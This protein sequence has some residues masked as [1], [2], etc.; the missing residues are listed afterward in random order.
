MEGMI[1][2][3]ILVHGPMAA[4]FFWLLYHTNKR[5]ES[6]ERELQLVIERN[7]EIIKKQAL[8][9]QS[10]SDQLSKNSEGRR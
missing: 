7:Q 4:A 1:Q 3:T 2:E 9:F 8:A 10:L 6:R 5:N